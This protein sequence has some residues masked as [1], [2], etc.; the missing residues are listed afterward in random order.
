MNTIKFLKK[1][2]KIN[3]EYFS[4]YYNKG[5]YTEQS[6][7]PAGSITIYVNNYKRLP[8][9]EGLNIINDSDSMT[10]YFESDRLIIYP[11]NKYYNDISKVLK[12]L[13]GA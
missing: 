5:N 1:G 9:I 8:R 4:V 11:N 12:V 7:I 10:D 6:K 2:L 13:K 3:G